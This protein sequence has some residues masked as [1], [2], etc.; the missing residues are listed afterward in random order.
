MLA[1]ARVHSVLRAL[2]I[3]SKM[4]CS[5]PQLYT[6]HCLKDVLL[7]ALKSDPGQTPEA[8]G[9]A[10][11]TG[12]AGRGPACPAAAAAAA[13][14]VAAAIQQLQHGPGYGPEI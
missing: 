13:A 8:P 11:G 9:R 7:I 4:C 5:S 14:A 10:G 1:Y 12:P 6:A 2:L 3:A